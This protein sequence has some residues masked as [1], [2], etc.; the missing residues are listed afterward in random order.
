MRPVTTVPSGGWL[1]LLIGGHS[2]AG[3]STL[4]AQIA[5]RTG[6]SHVEADDV[7]VA[8]QRVTT[9]DQLPALHFFTSAPGVAR[10]G[11]WQCDPQELVQ[12]LIGV[13][14]VVSRAL[15]PVVG[16][17]VAAA[18]PVVLEGDGILPALAAPDSDGW[19]PPHG[20]HRA[21]AAGAVRSVFLVE[22]DLEVVR[23]QMGTGPEGAAQAVM[24]WQYGQW[25]RAE[26]QR[27]GESVLPPRPYGTLLQRVLA[28][29]G[30][31]RV[32]D[33]IPVLP[34]RQTAIGRS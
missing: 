29:V 3:K 5:R 16:H 9:P 11:I 17:H 20:L 1:V 31:P 21:I 6:A 24:H 15:G 30:A 13:G 14:K 12:G 33:S 2:G 25:L 10:P 27:H 8:I 22:S 4:A 19:S 18:K 34:P 26:A 7:R 32:S 28:L 23:Q